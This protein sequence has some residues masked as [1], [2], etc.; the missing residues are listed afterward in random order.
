MEPLIGLGLVLWGAGGFLYKYFTAAEMNTSFLLQSAVSFG[1]GVYVL[2]PYIKD[3]LSN[4][5]LNKTK[6]EETEVCVPPNSDCKEEFDDFKALH[7]LKD[8]ALE[9]NNQE[10]MDLLVKLNTI[11]FSSSVKRP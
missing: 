4:L 3:R 2:Y 6:K 9:L 1:G 5:S 7:Y 11:M 8:R 10:A